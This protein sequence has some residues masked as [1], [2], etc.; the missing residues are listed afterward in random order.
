MAQKGIRSRRVQPERG[1]SASEAAELRDRLRAAARDL[2]GIGRNLKYADVPRAL[3]SRI[4]GVR[5]T[6]DSV[7]ERL[8]QER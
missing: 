4:S 7:A 2:D 8:D 5:R 1:I 3:K 6:V